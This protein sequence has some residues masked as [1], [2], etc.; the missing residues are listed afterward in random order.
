ML[1]KNRR[2]LKKVALWVAYL[3]CNWSVVGS[4]PSKALLFTLARNFTLITKYWL[5]T[6]TDSRVQKKKEEI[7]PSFSL[8]LMCLIGLDFY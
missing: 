5:I 6:G 4:A 7:Y 1:D 2:I 3:T 8:L